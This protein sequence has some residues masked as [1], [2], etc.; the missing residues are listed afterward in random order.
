MLLA[1]EVVEPG[2]FGSEVTLARGPD[3]AN[4]GFDGRLGAENS[5]IS[6]LHQRALC[7]LDSPLLPSLGF[8]I[9]EAFA[10]GLDEDMAEDSVIEISE[11]KLCQPLVR[12]MLFE[13]YKQH[14]K[15]PLSL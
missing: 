8:L 12:L 3:C 14:K 7:S 5:R 15:S 2:V 6:V 10:G 4:T 11:I 13:R 9:R 1:A